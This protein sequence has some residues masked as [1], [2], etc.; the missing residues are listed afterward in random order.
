[1]ALDLLTKI[2]QAHGPTLAIGLSALVVL[3]FV[4]S[5]LSG[6]LQRAGLNAGSAAF[7]VA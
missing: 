6:L 5:H 1:M 2:P 3:I 4:K 7:I